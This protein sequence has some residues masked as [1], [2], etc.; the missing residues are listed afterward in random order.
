MTSIYTKKTTVAEWYGNSVTIPAITS[1]KFAP[2]A[3]SCMGIAISLLDKKTNKKINVA[4]SYDV[5]T[6]YADPDKE[7]IVISQNFMRGDFSAIGAINKLNGSKS[8]GAILG[9]I[10]HEIGHFA[11][12]P[13]N[14]NG[15]ISHIQNQ[16]KKVFNFSLARNIANV[17]EDIFI[18]F[19]IARLAPTL[20]WTLDEINKLMLTDSLFSSVSREMKTVTD[21][22]NT[23]QI[24]N[25][26]L[27]AKVV[28]DVKRIS[29]FASKLF[30]MARSVTR[31]ENLKQ[32]FDLALAIYEI[33][34]P[35][36]PEKPSASLLPKQTPE[37]P[38]ND[39]S[40]SENQDPTDDQDNGESEPDDQENDAIENGESDES[41]ESDD[42]DS[43]GSEN[44]DSDSDT[45]GSMDDTDDDTDDQ[46]ELDDI[47]DDQ[48]ELEPSGAFYDDQDDSDLDPTDDDQESDNN[49]ESNDQK[50]GSGESENDESENDESGESDDQDAGELGNSDT[51]AIPQIDT[52]LTRDTQAI[53]DHVMIQTD[54]GYKPSLDGHIVIESTIPAHV[55]ES[56]EM[57]K[58]YT[59]LSEMA[60]Q[61]TNANVGYGAQQN[62]GRNLRQI[63]RIVTDQKVFSTRISQDTIKPS[64][65]ILLL[66][67]SGSMNLASSGS[68]NESKLLAASRAILGAATGL[69]SGKALVSV[70]GHTSDPY[71]RLKQLLIYRLMT[72]G[73]SLTT[74]A[75]RLYQ[76]SLSSW[77]SGV[78]YTFYN[79]DGYALYEISKKFQSQNRKRVLIVIS[80]GSPNG[81]GRDYESFR[82]IEHTKQ[83]VK[84]IRQ[85]GIDVYSISID[86]SAFT[87]NDTIYGK[88]FNTCATDPNAIDQLI[89]QLYK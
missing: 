7:L 68:M 46:T 27:F 60:R 9:V 29:P 32:R 82:A 8:V 45:D 35:V 40:D 34:A 53:P 66:D 15:Y 41:I 85:S 22:K 17:L 42:N 25:F 4:L 23:R 12:S 43:D 71:D 55:T 33:I 16:T 65:M 75:K 83:M 62:K 89:R 48:D 24:L 79:R 5:D 26:L 39:D 31:M 13:K 56:L 64:E 58:R 11:Y 2:F 49:D 10:V 37:T 59:R 21:A 1:P 76:L 51:D 80:D 44:D 73:E 61:R 47:D 87:V 67:C 77:K 88:E 6:A 50:S 3:S 72:Q 86:E 63:H 69:V 81:D 38:E 30:K 28:P 84:S 20:E 18:E 57:D 78:R 70:Y 74:L 54:L 52:F 36:A 14:L 19:Q